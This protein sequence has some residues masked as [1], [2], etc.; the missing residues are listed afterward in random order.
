MKTYI[1]A[2]NSFYN[3]IHSLSL[4]QATIT[5][6]PSGRVLLEKL[7]GALLVYKQPAF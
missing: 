1:S 2:F 4:Q 6:T 5:P 3:K 7:G